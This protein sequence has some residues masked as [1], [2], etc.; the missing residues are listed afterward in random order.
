M[1]ESHATYA[2][3]AIALILALWNRS[4]I[5]DSYPGFVDRLETN[6]S[7]LIV[8]TVRASQVNSSDRTISIAVWTRLR[9]EAM[10]LAANSKLFASDASAS[11]L[12]SP[13]PL[14]TLFETEHRFH[15]EE[16]RIS[17]SSLVLAGYHGI[18]YGEL[19]HGPALRIQS[20]E[21]QMLLSLRLDDIFA[22]GT[23]R[24]HN[25]RGRVEW[26][27]DMWF[28]KSETKLVVVSS[29]HQSNPSRH[30]VAVVDIASK[31]V[32]RASATFLEEQ[33]KSVGSR[34][35]HTVF[36][37]AVAHRVDGL[38]RTANDIFTD[39]SKPLPARVRAAAY[40]SS[41]GDTQARRFIEELAA[42][43]EKDPADIRH[44]D[45]SPVLVFEDDYWW[46]TIGYA[47]KLLRK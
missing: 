13:G 9:P 4:A 3:F 8:A 6:R 44:E 39:A 35:L 38:N 12:T 7:G 18:N 43:S 15:P 2:A 5:A 19:K 17:S 45:V 34:N 31:R 26:L 29:A 1:R 37:V 36:D 27:R 21:G 33:L 46:E 10:M 25:G 14:S 41:S 20:F 16:V 22:N 32:A 42:L 47:A 11:G 28:D 23:E 40:L 30:E 24:Y